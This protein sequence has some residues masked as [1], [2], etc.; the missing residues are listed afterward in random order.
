MYIYAIGI[1]FEHICIVY[2]NGKDLNRPLYLR[3]KIEW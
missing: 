3:Y 1:L 2:K